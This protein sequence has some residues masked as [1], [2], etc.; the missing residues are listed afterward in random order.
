MSGNVRPLQQPMYQQ[1][2]EL[3]REAIESGELPRVNSSSPSARW[4]NGIG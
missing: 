4:W 2:Q 3:L 1:L